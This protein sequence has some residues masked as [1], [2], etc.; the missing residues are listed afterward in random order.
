MQREEEIYLSRNFINSL[1]YIEVLLSLEV[2][3]L[4]CLKVLHVKA[5]LLCESLLIV[6]GIFFYNFNVIC[7]VWASILGD[8]LKMAAL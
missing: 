4:Y 7:I 5:K 6:E 8:F 2:T 1:A 3:L